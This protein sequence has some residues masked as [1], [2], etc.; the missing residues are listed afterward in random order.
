MPIAM[1]TPPSTP[2]FSLGEQ[3][4]G[5]PGNSYPQKKK[6]QLLWKKIKAF[7]KGPGM[8]GLPPN[9]SVSSAEVDQSS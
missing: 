7:K 1:I 2:I 8:R 4:M 3:R 9:E 5:Q 6:K